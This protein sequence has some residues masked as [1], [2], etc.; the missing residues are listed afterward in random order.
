MGKLDDTLPGLSDIAYDVL[1]KNTT[2]KDQAYLKIGAG[3][4]LINEKNEKAKS[5]VRKQFSKLTKEKV[6]KNQKNRCKLC[7]KKSDVWDFDHID[8]NKANN[9]ISNCQALC[10]NCHAKKTR[11]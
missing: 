9:D 1:Q 7:G 2:K 10:L 3:L 6:L 8:G 11:N 4:Y 5:G